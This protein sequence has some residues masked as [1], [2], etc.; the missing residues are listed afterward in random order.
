MTEDDARARIASQATDDQR[1]E[2]ADYVIDN[3]GD[4]DDLREEVATL[5]DALT[6]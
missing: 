5:W 3:G 2:V 4:I 6:R 1:R